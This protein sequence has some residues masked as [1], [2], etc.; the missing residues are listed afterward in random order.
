[1]KFYEALDINL[2]KNELICFVGAGGKT[3]S[4]FRL[5]K[6]LKECDKR[7]LVTTTTAIYSPDKSRCDEVIC[8]ITENSYAITKRI[9]PCICVLGAEV[10][11]D[12][13]LLG[14]DREYIAQLFLKEVF[15]YILV[16]ADGSKQKPVKAPADHE[17]VIPGGATKVVGVIGL[18]SLGLPIDSNFVHRPEQ[19]CRLTNKNIG[20]IIDGGAIT[21]LVKDPEGLFKTAHEGIRKYVLF[22]KADNSSREKDIEGAIDEIRQEVSINLNVIIADM[23]K[24]KIRK[25]L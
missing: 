18:D 9:E 19:F 15:D 1:M 3:T 2:N 17:P 11:A 13:K 7:V 23:L 16:E 21:K 20:D 10:S 6:E 22:N 8:N 5:A 24:G 12:N 14:V 4:I 25:I